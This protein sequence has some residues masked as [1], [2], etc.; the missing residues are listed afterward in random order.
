M[1]I[2]GSGYGQI[3]AGLWNVA[4]KKVLVNYK[5]FNTGTSHDPKLDGDRH[6]WS[7]DGVNTMVTG[8]LS[9]GKD[10]LPKCVFLP[11]VAK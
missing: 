4:L 9:L 1:L 6:G 10:L 7:K 11:P 3:A 8:M 2:N 5:A